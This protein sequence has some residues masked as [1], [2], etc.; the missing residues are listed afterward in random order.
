MCVSRCVWGG[1]GAVGCRRGTLVDSKKLLVWRARGVDSESLGG[2]VRD[3]CASGM[4]MWFVLGA[5]LVLSVGDISTGGVVCGV[6]PCGSSFIEPTTYST[7][8]LL[9][10]FPQ[11]PIGHEFEEGGSSAKSTSLFSIDEGRES[12]SGTKSTFELDE[13]NARASLNLGILF[14]SNSQTKDA[15]IVGSLPKFKEGDF[16][17]LRIKTLRHAASFSARK[18]F[19]RS[20][21]IQR[22]SVEDLQL[23]VESYQR[24]KPIG[25][26]LVQIKLEG[27][28]AYTYSDSEI[29]MM[30]KDKTNSLMGSVEKL[31]RV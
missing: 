6:C 1:K 14:W 30:N 13:G 20:V 22:R 19:P 9:H 11:P 23:G 15:G 4:V 12:K 25:L 10:S 31:T 29:I 16:Q 3:G 17:D 8:I 28:D 7:P 21:V 5:R 27:R 24:N 2:A 18:L 26:N